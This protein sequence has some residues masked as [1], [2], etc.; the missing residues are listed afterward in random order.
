[1]Y[2]SSG[3][4]DTIRSVIVGDSL[5]SYR[6]HRWLLRVVVVQN[7]ILR[8]IWSSFTTTDTRCFIWWGW[9]RVT[10]PLQN[11]DVEATTR[12]KYILS[13]YTVSNRSQCDEIYGPNTTP[14]KRREI[15]YNR[16]L[17]P[18]LLELSH[19]CWNIN[20]SLVLTKKTC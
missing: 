17:Q 15:L 4:I 19:S 8:T 13:S 16:H 1:L 11:N 20:P 14:T 10:I 12:D 7:F 3:C 5:D 6:I 2:I 18:F 9:R